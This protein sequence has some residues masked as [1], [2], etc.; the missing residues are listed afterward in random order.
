MA[1]EK[2]LVPA[3]FPEQQNFLSPVF[4][5]RQSTGSFVIFYH[6]KPIHQN[7]SVKVSRP[8]PVSLSAHM[9]MVK[10]YIDDTL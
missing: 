7:V 1:T 6:A 5:V 10:I 9:C 2:A 3:G 8:F 4:Q